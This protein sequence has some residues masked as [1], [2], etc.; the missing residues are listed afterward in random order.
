M[1]C[2]SDMIKNGLIKLIWGINELEME[3]EEP[4]PEWILIGIFIKKMSSRSILVGSE[5]IWTK[6]KK[7]LSE[8]VPYRPMKVND[9]PPR[10][11]LDLFI[12]ITCIW[13]F[14][15]VYTS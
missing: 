15:N 6:P 8:K 4:D 5:T 12:K 11:F 13:D 7:V 3:D 9:R 2:R 10:T 1:N 14:I